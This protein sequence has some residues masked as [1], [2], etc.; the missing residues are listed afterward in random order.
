[1]GTQA[2]RPNEGPSTLSSSSDLS[3]EE[4]QQ[5]FS[6]ANEECRLA[7]T[8]SIYA[9]GTLQYEGLAWRGELWLD[10]KTR[11]APPSL[12]D[13]TAALGP[14]YVHVDAILECVGQPDVA[15]TRQEIL[16]EVSA[17]LSVVMKRRFD[18]R[19]AARA[20]VWASDAKGPKCESRVP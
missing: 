6:E 4:A 2:W 13:E 14:R 8:E 17:F 16:L 5:F 7:V 3:L 1:M 19:K 15:K 18:C 9:R 11:L 10:D 12:Q 20:W